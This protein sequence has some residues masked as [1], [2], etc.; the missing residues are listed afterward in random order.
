VP[1]RP[2]RRILLVDDDPDVRSVAALVLTALGGYSVESCDSACVA[3]EIAPSFAPDL[4]LLDI[5]MPDMDGFGTLKALR[6]AEATA[7]TPVVL[8]SASVQRQESAQYDTLGCLGVIAK[9]FD[10][11]ALP[12]RLE[13]LWEVH[14]RRRMDAHHREFE[15]LRRAYVDELP[16]KINAMQQTAAALAA[17]GW[18]RPTVESL[19]QLTHRLAGS[20]GLYRLSALSR[21]A[22]ALEEIVKRLLSQPTWPP[23]S[24]PDNLAMLVHAVC[25]TARD[26]ARREARTAAAAAPHGDGAA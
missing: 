24:A 22:G 11:A 17:R 19:Y 12:A 10:P 9:P 25:R 23:S 3:L 14:T 20:S 21:T 1:H 2:L 5:M 7:T 16:E 6:E 4:V 18:D 26:E 8:M 13:T 15:A